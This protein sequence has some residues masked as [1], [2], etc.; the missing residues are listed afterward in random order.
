ME[1]T[2]VVNEL[3]TICPECHG[4]KKVIYRG[5]VVSCYAC[6]GIGEVV[7]LDKEVLK[8]VT[9]DYAADEAIGEY[10][11]RMVY[12]YLWDVINDEIYPTLVCK[13]NL[14]EGWV[15][16]TEIEGDPRRDDKFGI[17]ISKPKR[18]GNGE[19]INTK[20]Y[21]DFKVNV[22]DRRGNTI[23]ILEK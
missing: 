12:C 16:Y 21:C 23:I 13:C 10:N 4:E 18:D 8:K 15:E 3:Q 22:M 19:V 1:S 5:E 9:W 6:R 2:A 11:G 7:S 14:N 17:L 20:K